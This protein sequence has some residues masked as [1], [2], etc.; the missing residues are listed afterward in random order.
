MGFEIE[1]KF[2]VKDVNNVKAFKNSGDQG[3]PEAFKKFQILQG[4]LCSSPERTVRIRIREERAFL[5]IKGKSSKSGTTRFEWE[6]EIEIEEARQLLKI[7]QPGLIEKTRY[8]IKSEKHTFEVDVFHGLNQGLIL[9][10]V[11]LHTEDE[12]FLKPDWLGKEVT[13]DVRYYNSR[14]IKKPY[15]SW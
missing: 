15:N 5:T 1:K 3:N 8:L 7:C 14:L 10:E 9:A 2:L 13:G 4:Y 6:K 12:Q 11:E